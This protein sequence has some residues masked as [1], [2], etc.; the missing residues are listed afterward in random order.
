MILGV[1]M[2]KIAIE[3]K[4]PLCPSANNIYGRWKTIS[5]T[6]F[7]GSNYI[8]NDLENFGNFE[9]S[10]NLNIGTEDYGINSILRESF[11]KK[12][13]QSQL[14]IKSQYSG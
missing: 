1:I 6:L 10:F 9:Q 3:A 12:V 5:N 7:N 14:N 8:G 2:K 13:V 4:A 11:S